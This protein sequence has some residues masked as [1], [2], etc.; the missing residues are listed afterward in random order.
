MHGRGILTTVAAIGLSSYLGRR[1]DGASDRLGTLL[2]TITANRA[3]VLLACGFWGVIVDGGNDEV[4]IPGMVKMGFF[5][6]VL[7]LG[8]LE[9]LSGVA[10]MISMERDWV[11]TV[12]AEDGR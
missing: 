1:I 4:P 9:K 2:S 10:N 3:A 12:A 7:A 8:V 11:V 6:V 5:A